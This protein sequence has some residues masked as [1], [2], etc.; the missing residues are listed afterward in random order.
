MSTIG[1][2]QFGPLQNAMIG[3]LSIGGRTS[4]TPGAQRMPHTAGH[5]IVASFTEI[6]YIPPEPPMIEWWITP[7]FEERPTNDTNPLQSIWGMKAVGGHVKFRSNR[8][9]GGDFEVDAGVGVG[10][11]TGDHARI[12]RMLAGNP[13]P[14]DCFPFSIGP[15]RGD[16]GWADLLVDTELV[17]WIPSQFSDL[18]WRLCDV[19][20]MWTGPQTHCL[21]PD[22][23]R[24]IAEQWKR[25]AVIV[26]DDPCYLKN[27]HYGGTTRIKGAYVRLNNRDG[28]LYLCES[29]IRNDLGT[30]DLAEIILHELLHACGAGE[31]E[32][33]VITIACL[34]SHNYPLCLY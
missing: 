28:Y 30:D 11:R 34:G 2:D 18:A 1:R 19:M 21:P 20:K 3:P 13:E 22:L 16:E 32:A 4:Q 23:K 33:Y 27:P 25:T 14:D 5:P 12:E 8:G 15:P 24:C 9:S 6:E 17:H 26:V 29:A 7:H 31:F 10:G